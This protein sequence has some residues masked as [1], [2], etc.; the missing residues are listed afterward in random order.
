M[1]RQGDE[2]TQFINVDFDIRSKSDL[3][4]LLAA[5]GE[6][7]CASCNKLGPRTYW[8]HGDLSSAPES[9]DAAIRSLSSLINE[10]PPTP[11]KLWDKATTR[12]FD[13][14]VEAAM[15]PFCYEMVLSAE[16]VDAAAKLN[17]RIR[18]TVYAPQSPK[19]I[20]RGKPA[21]ARRQTAPQGPGTPGPRAA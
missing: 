16:A 17:A 6:Q 4:P 5:L 20:V 13:I 11:R 15:Q 21:P 2:E 14:G 1:P 8:V 19:K 10:L 12:E 7:V 3:G 18:F 9:A